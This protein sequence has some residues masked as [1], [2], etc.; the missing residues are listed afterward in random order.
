MSV[1][2]FK[3]RWWTPW[4]KVE[5]GV[6]TNLR[7]AEKVAKKKAFNHAKAL[8]YQVPTRIACVVEIDGGKTSEVIWQNG[9]ALGKK[10]WSLF[11][12][13]LSAL[14]RMFR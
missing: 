1:M 4:I 5:Y 10:K 13:V 6:V 7:D 2:K 3:K 11:R 14:T 9:H 8:Y 12:R